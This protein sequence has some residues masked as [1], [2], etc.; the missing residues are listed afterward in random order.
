MIRQE[1]PNFVAS[2]YAPNP[3]EVTYW[4]DLSASSDGQII[5]CYVNNKWVPINEDQNT[6]QD[7]DITALENR[8]T[9]LEN[10]KVDKTSYNK[11]VTESITAHNSLNENK[12][13]KSTTLA[14]YGIT[15]VY[16]KTQT[17]SQIDTKIAELVNQA[18]ETLNTLDELA[19]AL[20]DDP[21]FA[22]TVTELI[23]TKANSTDVY[24]KAQCN[25]AINEAITNANKVTSTDVTNI[26][27]VSEIPTIQE[28]GVLYIKIS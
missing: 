9:A 19:A 13:D 21:N 4:I 24:T 23:G 8:C 26:K 12:A 10:N 3:K 1:K 25:T 20:G 15:D 6:Q 27:V 16:T 2:R 14:G 17:N 28:T 5:K 7:K 22:T 18:P 11:F